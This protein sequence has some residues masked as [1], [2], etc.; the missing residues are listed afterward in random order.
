LSRNF[1]RSF[2]RIRE[3]NKVW[4]IK[5]TTSGTRSARY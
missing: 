1:V 2:R 5:V 3:D 4:L